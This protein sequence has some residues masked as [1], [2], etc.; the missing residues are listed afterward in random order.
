MGGLIMLF[1]GM[2]LKRELKWINLGFGRG[3]EEVLSL[4]NQQYISV[5]HQVIFPRKN[6]PFLRFLKP[7]LKP[8]KNPP[9]TQYCSFLLFPKAMRRE[10]LQT[11]PFPLSCI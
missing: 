6:L 11:F 3:N 10:C 7:S 5:F 2:F 4:C 8:T 1:M 9:K